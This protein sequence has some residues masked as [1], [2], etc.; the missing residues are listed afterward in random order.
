VVDRSTA[1]RTERNWIMAIDE[2][3]LG[4]RVMSKDGTHLG[5][6]DK[7]IVHVATD[8]IDGFL[9]DRGHF[10]PP[11]IVET[12]L[13]AHADAKGVALTLDAQAAEVLPNYFH[14]QYLHAPNP[15]TGGTAPG[16]Q[17]D[18][19]GPGEGW[20]VRG[21][22]GTLSQA[23]GGTSLLRAAAGTI[24]TANVSNVPAEEVLIGA[25]TDVVD[26]GGHK[27]G[28]VHD[29]LVDGDGKITGFVVTAGRLVRHELH[30]PLASVSGIA[31]DHIRLGVTSE[32]A[33]RT[34][35]AEIV[36]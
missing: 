33:T 34:A 18:A 22:S 21:P 19:H 26:D 36:Q 13:V 28:R 9:L 8:R 31:H 16:G 20:T 25:G 4:A 12:G 11:K 35:E 23:G 6:I 5:A 14:E 27:L 2:F 32:A 29:V 1:D 15:Q 30:V 24:E 10:S 3:T 7:L 17:M